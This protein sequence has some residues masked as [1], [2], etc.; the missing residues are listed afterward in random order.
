MS[1][2]LRI[3]QRCVSLG[4]DWLVENLPKPG[5]SN[6]IRLLQVMR[7]KLSSF[8][9]PS[10]SVNKLKQQQAK[11]FESTFLFSFI[12]RR[13]KA[14]RHFPTSRTTPRC[15]PSLVSPRRTCAP[16]SM[17]KHLRLGRQQRTH[18]CLRMIP[19][20]CLSANSC[21]MLDTNPRLPD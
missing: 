15:P 2:Y 14:N 5:N 11:Q 13:I 3:K 10:F 8:L 21:N 4:P 7:I 17:L 6:A 18:L 20:G 9:S 19:R 12:S 16:H 1:F